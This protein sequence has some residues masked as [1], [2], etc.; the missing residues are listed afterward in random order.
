MRKGQKKIEEAHNYRFNASDRGSVDLGAGGHDIFGN[1][2]SSYATNLRDANAERD[3][4]A[5]QY[6]YPAKRDAIKVI[7]ALLKTL[8]LADP[9]IDKYSH[10]N[11]QKGDVVHDRTYY[12]YDSE[13]KSELTGMI[14]L[15][16]YDKFVL[17]TDT[18]SRAVVTIFKNENITIEN[19][20]KGD[21]TSMYN[22]MKRN[23]T[24]RLRNSIQIPNETLINVGWDIIDAYAPNEDS[25]EKIDE[26]YFTGGSG[27][28]PY[29]FNNGVSRDNYGY[30]YNVR[31]LNHFGEMK[32][33]QSGSPCS[34][35]H[36][37]SKVVS[38]NKNGDKVVGRVVIIKKDDDGYIVSVFVLRDDTSKIIPVDIDKIRLYCGPQDVEYINY[39]RESCTPQKAII[40]ES[41]RR[42]GVINLN[43]NGESYKCCMQQG[44]PVILKLNES[45]SVIEKT[46]ILDYTNQEILDKLTNI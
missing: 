43:H 11:T 7:M 42:N 3:K 4:K 22:L 36:K 44:S 13:D 32:I 34:Y 31:N 24:P 21:N 9:A 19:E 18:I 17:K 8:G 41:I 20:Y 28:D 10:Y 30:R 12:F 45:G 39:I 16:S 46:N 2:D 23:I 38:V 27:L 26:M 5:Y 25:V 14:I 33:R 35:I 1:P 29:T 37:G 15:D 6:K 40:A